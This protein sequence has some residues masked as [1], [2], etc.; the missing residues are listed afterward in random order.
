MGVEE[1]NPGLHEPFAARGAED[2]GPELTAHADGH[3]TAG[4]ELVLAVNDESRNAPES[5]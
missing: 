4:V 2:T 1:G 5:P 3:T